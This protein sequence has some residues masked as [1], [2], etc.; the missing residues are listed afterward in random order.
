MNLE[1]LRAK[2]NELAD[3]M[4]AIA[5]LE[6]AEITEEQEKEFDAVEAELKKVDAKITRIEKTQAVR[7][8][9]EEPRP[10]A[11]AAQAVEARELA[12]G[13]TLQ[14]AAYPGGPETPR[15]FECFEQFLAAAYAASR[16]ER[17]DQRL[18]YR[19]ATRQEMDIGS[20]GG[21]M[22]P[23]EFRDELLMVEPAE[24][25]LL[26]MCRRLPAGA[27]PDASVELPALNQGTNQ[28]G[29]VTVYR[30]AE[31]GSPSEAQASLK[32]MGWTP[33][34][35]KGEVPLTEKLIRNWTGAQGFAQ[36]LL[37]AAFN[38]AFENE[39]YNG[40]GTGG[41]FTG[42]LKSKALKKINRT[43]INT[44]IFADLAE[45]VAALLQR[46]GPAVWLYNQQLLSALIQMKDG[47]NNLVWANNVVTGQP[48]TLWG[49]PAYP[50]EFSAA[51]GS[52]GDVALVRPEYYIIKDGA[53]P[54]IDIG[55]INTDFREGVVRVRMVMSNDGGPWLQEPFTLA[56]N[57][58]TVSP[59]VALDV[60]AS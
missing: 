58:V 16:G 22:V 3:K 56:A 21:Y 6:V 32:L 31:G 20:S 41:Q 52:L 17:V 29:G 49:L 47:N 25:P 46:G 13:E 7:A 27:S 30:T 28:H 34:E 23:T 39:I 57:S 53:G 44:F 50:Y 37:R 14:P 55:R 33:K 15:Q 18:D 10:S 24:T 42:I 8:R 38:A 26:S 1:Q 11:G 36:Q 35:I 51:K 59:F 2:R 45:M 4:D 60:P 48:P 54:M 19:A 5:K 43:T 12:A 9:L 40:I